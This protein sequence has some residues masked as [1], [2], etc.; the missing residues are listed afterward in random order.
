[1]L[2]NHRQMLDG[3]KDTF[4]PKRREKILR[5]SDVHIRLM[6]EYPEVPQMVYALVFLGSFGMAFAALYIY[7][8]EAPKWVFPDESLLTFTVT[9]LHN[10]TYHSPGSPNWNNHGHHKQSDYSERP[11]RIYRW[12]C[13]LWESTGNEYVQSIRIHDPRTYDPIHSTTQTR[14]LHQS[15]T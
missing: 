10:R 6:Q 3:I 4:R 2:N 15:P 11:V 12:P 1:M 9:F 7:V 14:I 13:G 8:P 5:D